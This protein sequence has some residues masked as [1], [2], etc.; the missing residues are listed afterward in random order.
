MAT[1]LTPGDDYII[2]AVT[3]YDWNDVKL[4]VNSLN[5]S[6]FQGTKMLLIYNGNQDFIDRLVHEGIV[7]VVVGQPDGQRS[8]GFDY[9]YN[10]RAVFNICVER[11]RHIPKLLKK[12]NVIGNV[13]ITDVKDVV[14]QDDP[15][16]Y[17]RK[18][19]DGAITILASSENILYRDEGWGKN[20]FITV[21]GPEEFENIQN[22]VIMNAGVIAG[23]G[24]EFIRMLE[25]VYSL[26]RIHS[27]YVVGGGGPDQ[28]AYNYVLKL[29]HDYGV[30]CTRFGTE[31]SGWAAQC[32]TTNDPNKDYS[33]VMIETPAKLMIDGQLSELSEKKL[34]GV[35]NLSGE[36]IAI[37]H[38]YDR[39][40]EWKKYF[41]EK[42][43]NVS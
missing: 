24:Y 21:F 2:G 37:I 5:Q 34:N 22:S 16:K 25:I 4:W 41:T 17:M 35:Y 7:P 8:A 9:F 15:A 11:F 43:S 36:K 12:L 6:G 1:D 23:Q 20:N 26:S 39:N 32:G 33:G 18:V 31:Q 19:L 40:P 27:P 29:F 28:A 14:F 42:F 13:L 38:Q 30:D 3:D 10:H